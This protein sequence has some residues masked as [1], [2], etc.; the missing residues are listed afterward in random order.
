GKVYALAG[1]TSAVVLALVALVLGVESIARL[2]QPV[3]IAIGEALP[4]AVLG[5]AVNVLCAWLLEGDA[6]HDDHNLRSAHVHVVADAFTSLLAIGALLGV[7]YLGWSYLD[8][9]MGIVGAT[10]ILRWA[11]KL[12]RC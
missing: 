1:Y 5:L 11:W 9:A 2:W 10:F 4:V 3:P 7:R 6:E 8:P 12:C